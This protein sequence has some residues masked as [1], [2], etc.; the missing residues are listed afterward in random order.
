MLVNRYYG[1]STLAIVCSVCSSG[2]TSNAGSSSC[3]NCPT[4]KAAPSIGSASCANCPVGKFA[5]RT[6][7]SSCY[8]C[9]VGKYANV[10]GSRSC[11]KCAAGSY[12]AKVESN[13]T[14]CEI[15]RYNMRMGS[16][17]CLLCAAGS[18]VGREGSRSCTSCPAGQYSRVGA[19][20]CDICVAGKYNFVRGASSCSNCPV[21]KYSGNEGSVSCANC[22]HGFAQP[23]IGQPLCEICES[24][25]FAGVGY[26]YCLDCPTSRYSDEGAPNCDFCDVGY[27]LDANSEYYHSKD[28][29]TGLCRPCPKF[30]VKCKSVGQTVEELEIKPGFWRR[31]KDDWAVRRC[32]VGAACVGGTNFD[33]SYCEEGAEG[34]YCQVCSEEFF[35]ASTSGLGFRCKRCDKENIRLSLL[36]LGISSLGVLIAAC[37][38]CRDRGEPEND[39]LP[40]DDESFLSTEEEEKEKDIPKVE[41]EQK[42]E[43]IYH[44]Q[45]KI[46]VLVVFCQIISNLGYGL[47]IEF[48][49]GYS[50]LLSILSVFSIDLFQFFP[51]GCLM[52]YDHYDKLALMTLTPIVI[53]IFLISLHLLFRR[54]SLCRSRWRENGTDIFF[55]TFLAM[56]YL[57]L[58]AVSNAIFATFKCVKY[59]E[60]TQFLRADY[61]LFCEEGGKQIDGRALWV[62]Y[63]FGMVFV[64]PVGIPLLFSVLLYQRRYELCPSMIGQKFWW[65]FLRQPDEG[66]ERGIEDE[67]RITYLAFLHEPFSTQYF[68]YV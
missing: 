8:L 5:D 24:G 3:S 54:S 26:K 2:K 65:I 23:A 34:P 42:K 1:T 28:T 68:W 67:E 10:T 22:T 13:C 40:E 25:K 64:Y 47:Q 30:G 51:L 50:Q 15:G 11:S 21:G 36:M 66:G 38:C 37:Y 29:S 46:R 19:S 61:T 52:Q 63:A 31:F 7:Q 16:T 53:S 14:A 43:F 41:Y 20:A 59:D 35:R 44:A 27:F 18:Y 32:P 57:I 4:G 58:P 12:S 45:S 39:E 62:T 60:E 33:D 9:G 56:M 48:P 49:K 55:A 6:G 17:G